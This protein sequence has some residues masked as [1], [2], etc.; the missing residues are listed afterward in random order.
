MRILSYTQL[1]QPVLGPEDG[2]YAARGSA[3]DGTGSANF[4]FGD[5]LLVHARRIL[6]AARRGYAKPPAALTPAGGMVGNSRQAATSPWP[7]PQ[8]GQSH[9]ALLF[10]AQLLLYNNSNSTTNCRPTAAVGTKCTAN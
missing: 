5:I 10:V 6:F 2:T 4:L 8:A 7:M 1:Y 9:E 3:P